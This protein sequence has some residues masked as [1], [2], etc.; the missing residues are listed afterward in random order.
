QNCNRIGIHVLAAILADGAVYSDVPRRHLLEIHLERVSMHAFCR[1]AIGFAFFALRL[2]HFFCP[3]GRAATADYDPRLT[4]APLTLPDPVNAYR[5]GNGAP[6]PSYW[7]N[8]AD[9]ELH[10]ELDTA[11][12]QLKAT[13]TIS[14]TNNSPDLLRSLWV[15]LE[16]NI[17]KSDSRAKRMSVFHGRRGAEAAKAENTSP[18][19]FVL[20]SVEIEAG[21]QTSKAE[22]IVSDTRMQ[23]RLAE[24]L[25]GYSGGHGGQLKIHIRYH[26]QI[27]GVWGGRTSWGASE[28]GE[29]YDMAQ[30]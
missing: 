27:P 13:E 8:E 9:Y 2:Q 21:K 10:A 29:I 14:Y 16:Q 22:Y 7:Q 28:K 17:Y 26:Y 4:F 12:K 30:W 24:P 19:G 18:D 20:D 11:A 23:I 1:S 15:Q 6:G 25:M 5:S 3:P